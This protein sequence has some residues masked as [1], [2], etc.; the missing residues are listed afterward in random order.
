MR[1]GHARPA[2]G[3]QKKPGETAVP[4][5]PDHKHVRSIAELNQFLPCLASDQA[6]GDIVRQRRP[7]GARHALLQ[8]L[9][10]CVFKIRGRL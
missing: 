6:R 1:V 8:E 2:D 5:F 3:A 10:G 7:E 4:T 9:S